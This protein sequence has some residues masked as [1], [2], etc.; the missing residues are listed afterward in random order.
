MYEVKD[1]WML[2]KVQTYENQEIWNCMEG[3]T[4][5]HKLREPQEDRG[6]AI[7]LSQLPIFLFVIQLIIY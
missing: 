3:F 4:V 1:C 2:K 5:E 6:L 7:N